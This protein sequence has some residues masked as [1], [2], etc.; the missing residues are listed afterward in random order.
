MVTGK[1]PFRS[2]TG[3]IDALMKK[4]KNDLPPPGK[5]V[6]GLSGRTDRAIRRAMSTARE[7]RPASCPE[8]LDDLLGPETETTSPGSEDTAADPPAGPPEVVPSGSPLLERLK[9]LGFL[10]AAVA[11]AVVAGRFLFHG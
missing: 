1:V 7:E 10:A 8:F 6:A 3:P 9:L 5:L 2:A 11:A 4:I